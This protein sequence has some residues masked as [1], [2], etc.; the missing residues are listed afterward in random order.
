MVLGLSEH[1][2]APRHRLQFVPGSFTRFSADIPDGKLTD[3]LDGNPAND[4]RGGFQVDSLVFDPHYDGPEWIV[5][6]DRHF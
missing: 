6:G 5:P 3:L 2:F 4:H 1:D